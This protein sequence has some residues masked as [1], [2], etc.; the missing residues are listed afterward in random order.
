MNQVGSPHSHRPSINEKLQFPFLLNTPKTAFHFFFIQFLP[1]FLIPDSKAVQRL[2]SMGSRIPQARIFNLQF[3]IQMIFPLKTFP[4][5]LAHSHPFQ[6]FQLAADAVFFCH[7]RKK[8]CIQM[9]DS[10]LQLAVHLPICD[11]LG[12]SIFF[13]LFQ[14]NIPIDPHADTVRFWTG[15]F[16]KTGTE[17]PYPV[18]QW[19]FFIFFFFSIY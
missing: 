8:L 5:F 2:S 13:Y 14:N 10:F 4:D 1:V 9:N 17:D 7:F 12:K 16:M 15:K 11:N 6:V 19:D 3:P 18:K